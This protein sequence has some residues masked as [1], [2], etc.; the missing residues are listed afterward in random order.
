MANVDYVLVRATCNDDPSTNRAGKH[1]EPTAD[2]SINTT[3]F[4]Y[5]M[6]SADSILF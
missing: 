1:L 4:L 3:A 6:P 2:I 5:L